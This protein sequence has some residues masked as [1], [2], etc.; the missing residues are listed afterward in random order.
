MYDLGSVCTCRYAL[1]GVGVC[2]WYKAGLGRLELFQ[3]RES[4]ASLTSSPFTSA[5]NVSW[6]YGSRES[7]LPFWVFRL[8]KTHTQVPGGLL[9][10]CELFS[11][12]S[13]GGAELPW[14]VCASPSRP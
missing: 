6:P 9:F 10:I 2:I 13:H 5:C 12:A 3:T 14:A 4:S 7:N 11:L 1:M 8:C